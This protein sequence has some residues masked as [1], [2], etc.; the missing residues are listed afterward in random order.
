MMI[1]E[2][3]FVEAFFTFL[4]SYQDLSKTFTGYMSVSD[5]KNSVPGLVLGILRRS[6][7]SF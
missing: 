4:N 5:R 2:D 7:K 3:T 6:I 1:H